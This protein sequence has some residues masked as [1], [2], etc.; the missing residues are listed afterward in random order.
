[1]K[2]PSFRAKKRARTFKPFS[3][4]VS[5]SGGFGI[6]GEKIFREA[7]TTSVITTWLV[8]GKSTVSVGD[9]TSRVVTPQ[10]E[11]TQENLVALSKWP[12]HGHPLPPPANGGATLG[13]YFRVSRGQVI[14]L[15]EIWIANRE[16]QKLIPRR[17]LFPCVTDA[18]DVI[19]A[20]G[21]L[22]DASRLRRVIDLPADL[23]E[24]SIAERKNVD[25]F[26]DAAAKAGAADTY[27]ARHRKPWWRV[28]LKTP[29]PIIMSYMGRRPPSFARNAC[30]ARLINVAHSLTPRRPLDARSQARWVAWL[31]QNVR[32]S[33]GRT[34]G[35]GMVKFEPGDAMQIPLPPEAARF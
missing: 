2:S 33:G 11:T 19:N 30:R 16:T 24:L 21:S 9:L 7:L 34:Y 12:G 23:G 17:Y 15:N 6:T 4:L 1:L 14:G 13:D 28:A 26:L 31:N 25:L 18:M 20:N 8:G 35:G 29:P 32:L 3:L 27:I 5:G 10:F 22:H